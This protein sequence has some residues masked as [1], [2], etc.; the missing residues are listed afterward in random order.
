MNADPVKCVCCGKFISYA[1]LDHSHE[2]FEPL[3][4]FGPEVSEWTC[5]S[6]LEKERKS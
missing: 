5:P 6:C 4:E 3:N 1:A 2:Y